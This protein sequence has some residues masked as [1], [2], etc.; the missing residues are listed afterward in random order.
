M[1]STKRISNSA[2]R[3]NA[4]TMFTALVSS[5]SGFGTTCLRIA[6]N[7]NLPCPAPKAVPKSDI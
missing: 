2:R 4:K 7:Y 1:K 5:D 3:T 6:K